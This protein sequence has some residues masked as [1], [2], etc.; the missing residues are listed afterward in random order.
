MSHDQLDKIRGD[1]RLIKDAAGLEL[2]FGRDDIRANLW[3]AACGALLAAWSAL[4]PWGYRGVIAIPLTLAALGGLW[5]A[6][7]AHQKRATRPSAWREHRLGILAMLIMLPLVALYMQWEKRAGMPREIVG[8]AAVFFVGVA[9]LVVSM[10]DRR[11]VSYIAAAVPLMG[12]GLA[13]PLL[14]RNQVVLA[15]GVCMM[16]ACLAAAFIQSIQLKRAEN[17]DDP[18]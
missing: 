13:I 10:T 12:F 8:A 16:V 14:A 1:L 9:A 4:A 15:G 6:R 2:P 18:H 11:R 3:V 17:P 7:Q 5:S